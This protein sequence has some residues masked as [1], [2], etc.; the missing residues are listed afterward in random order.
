MSVIHDL[1]RFTC[2]K[3]VL[4][5]GFGREG[6]S[7]LAALL[8]Y[9]HPSL[10]G[11]ADKRDVQVGLSENV[12]VHSGDDYLKAIVDYDI[13]FCAPGIPIHKEAAHY[14]TPKQ[15]ITSQTD[16][17]LRFCSSKVVGVTGTKGKS[18]T[19]TLIEAF[20]RQAGGHAILV[21]N[22]GAPAFD[23]LEDMDKTDVIIYELS[24]H[25]LTTTNNSPHV[26]I[27]LNLLP[28][29]LDY[30]ASE[31]SYYDAKE[32]VF[33]HQNTSDFLITYADDIEL[34]Q[35][36]PSA[37]ANKLSFS[38]AQHTVSEAWF[39]DHHIHVC[40]GSHKLDIN[41]K[42]I[43]LMG[44]I[45]ANNIMAALLAVLVLMKLNSDDVMTVLESFSGLPHRLE[46][47]GTF[48]GVQFINDAISTMPDTT[49]AAI[50]ACGARVN[51]LILGGQDRPIDR[52]RYRA[53][54]IEIKRHDVENLIF[55]HQNGHQ[56]KKMLDVYLEDLEYKT[57]DY[58]AEDMA[59]AV[60]KAYQLTKENSVCLLSPAA[61]SFGV[62]K[63]YAERGT[64]FKQAVRDKAA[65]EKSQRE[66]EV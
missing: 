35:R 10:I 58:V 54:A 19:S 50:K 59:M 41:R 13:V 40:M 47:I 14:F 1:D 36:T 11:I 21:G 29:H 39:D 3:K 31:E 63:D 23:Q 28:E 55:I 4:I 49:C 44:D 61:P 5:L 25:Q 65:D 46:H 9:C 26:A 66:T 42:N 20:I 51:T 53:L 24:S 22:V 8:T 62:Y 56:L 34:Q 38:S 57:K 32:A 45:N 33:S 48:K 18:T 2:G 12:V 6:K 15:C 30:Y 17:I 37:V 27:L 7:T 43:Q 52:E 64:V 60:G 16:M